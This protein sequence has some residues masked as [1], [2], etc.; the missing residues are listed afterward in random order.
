MTTTQFS[1]SF[2]TIIPIIAPWKWIHISHN[3]IVNSNIS[4][5]PASSPSKNKRTI[6]TT[7]F[8][9]FFFYFLQKNILIIFMEQLIEQN[10]ALY[11]NNNKKKERKPLRRRK[12]NWTLKEKKK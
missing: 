12:Q 6:K 1:S 7:T 9:V 11:N 3:K 5:V 8:S 4:R 2:V 10:N